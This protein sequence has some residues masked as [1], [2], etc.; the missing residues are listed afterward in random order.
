MLPPEYL[1]HVTDD[2]VDL[3]SQLDQ[4]II[5]D[6]VRRIMKAGRITD[7]AAWQIDRVQDS[8]LLYNE[9]IAEVSK[10]SGASESQVRALFED[11]GVEAI[12]YDRTIYIAAGLSP[13]P[14]AMS[15][16]AQ[17]VLNAGLRKTSGYLQNLTQTTA[18]GAQQAYIHAATIAEMQ[19]DSGA[20]DYTTAIRNAVRSAI[21]GGNWI[22]YPTGHH[23]RLDVATRRAVMTGVNQTSAQ[24]SLAYADDMGCDLVET[25]AHIGAR[26]E[27]A[28]WQG[29][30]FS[31]SGNN[32]KYPDFVEN[33]RYGYGD[34]LC[35]WNCRHNFYP[36]FEGI[37]ESAYPKQKLDEYKN[38]TVEYQ[39]EKMSYY[40]A[41]QRQRAMER[42]VRDSKRQAAGYDEAVKSAKDEATA[43]AMKQ[44]FNSAAV[45]LKQQESILKDFTQKTGL[46]RQR[47]LE[48]VFG[49][50]RS[51]AQK[52]V[53]VNKKEFQKYASFLGSPTLS[54]TVEDFQKLR[55]NEPEKW[56]VIKNQFKEKVINSDFSE[57]TDFV[58]SLDN[59]T[60]R[61]WYIAHDKKI[62]EIVDKSLSLEGQ[63]RQACELRNRYRTQ[64]RDLMRDQKTRKALDIEHSNK[65][66]EETVQD[67]MKRKGI[68]RDEALADIVKTSAKPNKT[69]NK[70]LGLEE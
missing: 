18:S 12:N 14:L 39:G 23:D 58:E 24:V 67:K 40:D 70:Q 2:I 63:A 33:T 29:K 52:A 5:R 27:H 3:Y 53:Y 55:Y 36:Y 13:P 26:P 20:F 34:G 48:Q 35:G 44:E 10:F 38:K 31:R 45:K 64:A 41:T 21:E 30:V 42:A 51:T 54:K 4:I 8:G 15:P 61:K 9:V 6:I 49:F 69:V 7:T 57:L 60:V 50:G 32:R 28:V 37:S 17:Q 62:P 56:K 25:T 46:E 66:F 68:S 22:T 1:E 59:V 47:N 16:T 11:F 43:K 19:V 65:S